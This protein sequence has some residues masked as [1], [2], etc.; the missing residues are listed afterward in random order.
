MIDDDAGFPLGKCTKRPR[1]SRRVAGLDPIDYLAEVPRSEEEN[2]VDSIRMMQAA[3]DDL[4]VDFSRLSE[5]SNNGMLEEEAGVLKCKDESRCLE[6]FI[7]GCLL[8][9]MPAK[10]FIKRNG[11]M[12]VQALLK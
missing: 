4:K 7:E 8:N 2:D 1:Q 11:D 12:S 10:E 6:S 9:K 5:V 3:S